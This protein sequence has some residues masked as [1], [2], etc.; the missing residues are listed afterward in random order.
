MFSHLP[1]VTQLSVAELI[2]LNGFSLKLHCHVSNDF[3]LFQGRIKPQ[4]MP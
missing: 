4:G 3:Q 2:H 1:K